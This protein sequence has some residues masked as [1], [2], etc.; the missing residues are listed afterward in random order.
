MPFSNG[1]VDTPLAAKEAAE[2]VGL[3]YRRF[4]QLVESGL[5]KGWKHC[6]GGHWHFSR[7]ELLLYIEARKRES[8]KDAEARIIGGGLRIM[9]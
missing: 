5:I 9:R 3:K 1:S 2:L 6:E 4:L 7:L 8:Q